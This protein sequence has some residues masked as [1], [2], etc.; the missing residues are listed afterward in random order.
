M[1]ELVALDLAPGPEFVDALRV[2]VGRRRRGA[3]GRPALASSRR[4]GSARRAPP[5]PGGVLLGQRRPARRVAD[6][7]RG[8]PRRADQREHRRA[9]R[10]RPHPHGAH[11]FGRGLLGET[12]RRPRKRP[13]GRLSAARAHRGARGGRA[14]A[15]DRYPVHRARTLRP[16]PGRSSWWGK[17]RPWSHS[18]PPLWPEWMPPATGRC[19]SA[20]ALRPSRSPTTWSPP[21]A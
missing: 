18:S 10:R 19:S 1:P 15:V 20:A 12:R 4:H 3:P 16:G 17:V 13:V 14:R 8:R 6:R 7:G 9:E 2:G 21:T 11:R 5:V